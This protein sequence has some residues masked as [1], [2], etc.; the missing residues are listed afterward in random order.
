MADRDPTYQ[1]DCLFCRMA[2]GTLAAP[3]L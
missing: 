3:K 2:S 1:A